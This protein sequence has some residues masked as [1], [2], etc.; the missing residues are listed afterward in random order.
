MLFVLQSWIKVFTYRNCVWK[1][2]VKAFQV[3][4]PSIKQQEA[5]VN[6][7]TVQPN[8][9]NEEAGM[10]SCDKYSKMFT[11]KQGPMVQN[12][13]THQIFDWKTKCYITICVFII[14]SALKSVSLAIITKKSLVY[15][16]FTYIL[17]DE[18]SKGMRGKYVEWTPSLDFKNHKSRTQAIKLKMI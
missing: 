14:I 6:M 7:G 18:C 10:L 5:T 9:M 12:N 15:S 11:L 17:H 3:W 4:I 2:Q 1:K 13:E 8:F 16:S